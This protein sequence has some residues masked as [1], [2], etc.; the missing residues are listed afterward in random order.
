MKYGNASLGKTFVIHLDRDEDLLESLREFVAS[1][2]IR[3]GVILSGFGTLD[4]CRLHAISTAG[5][6][7][8]DEFTT[9]E[10]PLELVGID[11]V[12]ANGDIHAHFEV[13]NLKGSFGGH[14]EPGCRV[15]YLCDLVVAEIDNVDMAFETCPETGLRLLSVRPGYEKVGPSVELD[16]E[17]KV[18]GLGRAMG[19]RRDAK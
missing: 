19:W 5:L 11:G 4:R 17:G 3:N 7:P 10:G 1:Q 16:G 8:R 14:L 18:I 6:P 2:G 15:L 13:A 9:V 12:I